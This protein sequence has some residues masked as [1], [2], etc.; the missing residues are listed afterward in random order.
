M[1]ESITIGMMG[2]GQRGI[3]L[4]KH[5]ILPRPD[6]HVA[7]VCDM[8]EDRV[9]KA[10]ELTVESGRPEPVQTKNWRDMLEMR[11]IDAVVIA[12][13]WESHI[14]CA[15]EIMKAGKYVGMEVG[16]AYSLRECW[17]LVETYERTGVP[18]MILENCCYGRYEMLLK[19]M[20]S[21]GLFG[22]LVHCQGG[23]HHDLREEIA[24]GGENRHY[25]L[26]NYLNRNCENYPTHE[27]GPLAQL[28][29]INHGNRM[30]SLCS[31]ASKA[32]GLHDYIAR[33]D[34][35]NKEL[36]HR[37]VAQGDVVTTI[38]TCAGGETIVLTLDTTLP[39]A[40]SRGLEVRGTRGM[41]CEDNCSFFFDGQHQEFDFKWREQWN[42][43]DQY[44]QQYE[45]PVWKA[46]RQAGIRGGHDGMDWLVFSDFFKAVK[47]ETQTPIDV[48]DAAAWM[49]IT[50]LSEQSI[51][52]GGAPVAIPDFTRGGWL[53]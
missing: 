51:A 19:N 41:Y 39:R 53:K 29:G 33:K 21:Q 20:V 8:Y 30:I 4:L 6:V 12:A 27:L 9:K 36:L 49:C 18:C 37:R 52:L 31:V 25:R 42:N 47:E 7:A 48:Y 15:V 3:G 26:R 13:S 24:F 46:Y 17:Q 16:G 10:A 11:E 43:A 45:H 32:A 5:V 23:Y 34:G 44:L 22:E 28:L 1:K 35:A 40:Y 2:F 14:M 50:P 38:I